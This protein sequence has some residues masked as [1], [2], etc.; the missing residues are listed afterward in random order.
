MNMLKAKIVRSMMFISSYFP[1]Y[2]LL[3]ILQSKEFGKIPK[4]EVIMFIITII[5]L[6]GISLLSVS[7]LK[8]TNASNSCKPVGVKRPDDKVIDYVFTYVIPLLSFSLSDWRYIT[9]NILLFFLLWFLYIKLDLIFINPLWGMF[10]YIAYE[11]EKGYIITNMHY[12]DVP[13][14]QL[15]RGCY[16]TNRIFLA[17]KCLNS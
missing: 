10:G 14:R 4:W 6:I 15:L 3:L 17:R 8:R 12:E 7:L 9:I 11:Y 16:L 13:R 1:L 5:I 2:V